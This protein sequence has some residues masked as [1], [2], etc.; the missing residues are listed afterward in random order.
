MDILY[1]QLKSNTTLLISLF[2][3]FQLWSTL[4]GW[5]LHPFSMAHSFFFLSNS[6]IAGVYYKIVPVH[7]LYPL[8]QPWNQ[9]FLQGALVTFSGQCYLETK[10]WVLRVLL[11]PW[12]S[13]FS[14]ANALS[15]N[16]AWKVRPKVI[17]QL[18]HQQMPNSVL[19]SRIILQEQEVFVFS[20]PASTP[21]SSD[22]STLFPFRNYHCLLWTVTVGL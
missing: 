20:W 2:K 12:M 10:I 19:E 3:L 22:K 21:H 14:R 13:F 4:P 9:P 5:L 18:W 16:M 6:L 17:W 15:A 8:S 11:P 7:L 1:F